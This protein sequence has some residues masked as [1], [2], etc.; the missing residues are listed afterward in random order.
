MSERQRTQSTVDPPTTKRKTTQYF[1][2]T[3]AKTNDGVVEPVCRADPG[4]S[5]VEFPDRE[6][7]PPAGDECKK[8]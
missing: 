4:G 8:L 2:Q 7:L 3:A 6:L 1:H 5:H